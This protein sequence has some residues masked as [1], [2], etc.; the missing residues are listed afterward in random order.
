MDKLFSDEAAT[1][2]ECVESGFTLRLYQDGLPTDKKAD[3]LTPDQRQ[4]AVIQSLGKFEGETLA[5]YHAYHVML[6]GGADDDNGP[7]FRVGNVICYER[8]SGFVDGKVCPSDEAAISL[9]DAEVA[10]V[11]FYELCEAEHAD[12]GTHLDEE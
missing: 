2:T 4:E 3:E 8:D 10:D 6:E 11:C 12:D 9:W 1:C 5:T 7:Y